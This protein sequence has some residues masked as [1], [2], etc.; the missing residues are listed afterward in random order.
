MYERVTK[1]IHSSIDI[2]L[3]MH[4]NPDADCLGSS[5][6]MYKYLV[7]LGKN[8]DIFLEPGEEIRDNLYMLPNITEVNKNRPKSSYDL[9]IALDC[10]TASRIGKDIYTVYH[11]RCEI[12]VSFDHHKSYSNFADILVLEPSSA[13]TTQILYKF[14]KEHDESA[15]DYEVATCL[16]AG[17]VTDSGNFSFNSTT[18]ETFE[19]AASLLSYNIDNYKITREL[20]MEN[21]FNTFNLSL[22]ALS[23][24]RF[25]CN[26]QLGIIAF[27]EED[28]L[29]TNTK[30]TDTEGIINNI[31]NI[32]EIVIA[33]SI[34][35]SKPGEFKVGLRSKGD[36]DCSQIAE[37]FGGG[38]HKNASGCKIFGE[39]ESVI[40]KLVEA[41]LSF[42]NK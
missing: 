10:A 14:F 37:L 28:F 35:E 7:N 25:Y 22:A 15:I 4:I 17:L 12:K 34:V 21:S 29:A 19:I 8:V 33:I 27:S 2:A 1:A 23:K 30:K 20:Y 9:G 13:S 24:A 42:L 39:K 32:K 3:F 18:K 6:A 40:N 36:F 31:V 41:S 5:L 26:N 16:F 11:E 38:G